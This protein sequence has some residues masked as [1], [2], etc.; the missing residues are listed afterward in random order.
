MAQV[1]LMTG[2]NNSLEETLQK[3][4]T[5]T[6]L[7][8]RTGLDKEFGLAS[9]SVPLH[10]L[11]KGCTRLPGPEHEVCLRSHIPTHFSWETETKILYSNTSTTGVLRGTTPPF[12]PV[13]IRNITSQIGLVQEWFLAK[14]RENNDEPSSKTKTYLSNNAFQSHVFLRQAKSPAPKAPAQR[15]AANGAQKAE[16]GRG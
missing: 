4:S 7:A 15:A 16:A 11:Q 12:E 6:S 5:R 2:A 1:P 14:L 13:T 9:L 10:L 8:L 3:I